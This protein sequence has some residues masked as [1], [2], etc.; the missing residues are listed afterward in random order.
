MSFP[1]VLATTGIIWLSHGSAYAQIVELREV[2]LLVS[3]DAPAQTAVFELVNESDRTI[4]YLAVSCHLIDDAGKPL[5]VKVV[6]FRE[7]PPG[8]SVGDAGF[9]MHVRGADAICRIIHQRQE[10]TR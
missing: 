5:A 2:R 7:V 1:R 10:D 4:K 9:P 3:T 6:R 8:S